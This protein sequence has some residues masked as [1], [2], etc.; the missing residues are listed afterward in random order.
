MGPHGAG[1]QLSIQVDTPMPRRS[2]PDTGTLDDVPLAD[3]LQGLEE[4][5]KEGEVR[6]E[7]GLGL[8][9][10]WFRDGCLLDAEMGDAHGEAAIFRLLGAGAGSYAIEYKSVA[11]LRM[12]HETSAALFGR[13]ARRTSEWQRLVAEMPSLDTVLTMD[14]GR[15]EALRTKVPP[16]DAKLLGLVDSKRS[17]VEIVDESGFE[18]VAALERLAW[19]VRA[20]LLKT[21]PGSLAPPPADPAA[22]SRSRLNALA[23]DLL[24]HESVIHP[25]SLAGPGHEPPPKPRPS[26]RPAPL[27]ES[28]VL[29]EIQAVLLEDGP[30]ERAGS[31]SIVP[32]PMVAVGR[33]ASAFDVARSPRRSL[34]PP[35]TQIGLMPPELT[36]K[37]A[38]ELS[39]SGSLPVRPSSRPP[40]SGREVD[41]W[42]GK[43]PPLL[44]EHLTSRTERTER[45]DTPSDPPPSPLLEESAPLAPERTVLGRYE[46]L[47]R[48]A[49]GGMGTVYLCRVTGEGG[50]RRLF[51]LKVL[52]RHLAR[53]ESAA[54]MFLQEAQVASRIYDPHVVGIVDVGSYGAQPYLVMDYVEGG[55]FHDLLQRHPTY[56]PPRLLVPILLDALQGLHAAHTLVD[57]RG[58][59][60]GLVH[61]D[62]SPH[63]LLVGIDGCGRLSDF[64]IAKAARAAAGSLRIATRGKP[65][66][67][68][69]EQ[70]AHHPVDPRTDVFSVG[71]VLWNALT[72]QRLFDGATV[73]ETIEN[74]LSRP[75]PPPSAVGLRPPP[76]LDSICLKALERK[77]EHRYQTAEEMMRDLRAVAIREDLLG[78]P[79]DVA[80]WV[81]ATFGPE[82]QARRLIA[83]DAS[84]RGRGVDV[85]RALPEA[86]R[87][88]DPPEAFGSSVSEGPPSSGPASS[89]EHSRTLSLSPVVPASEET[90]I[91]EVIRK[92]ILFVAVVVSAI[93]VLLALLFPQ[94]IARIFRLE[95]QGPLPRST[96]S[97]PAA[98]PGPRLG[99]PVP[100]PIPALPTTSGGAR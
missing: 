10:I 37:G 100:E 7:T 55:S 78:S 76:C 5:Q 26:P 38:P 87:L 88:S 32:T 93:A 47:S 79:G 91:P 16:V 43:L 45:A 57:D 42:P 48:I 99:Q 63:N 89:S 2:V 68:A 64:G 13:R 3:M 56:R 85:P 60:L 51:A 18:A 53:D 30:P 33:R 21:R 8:A 65:A 49:R 44:P 75:I 27:V 19:Y 41:T 12:I 29:E 83:L 86:D 81:A 82:L 71:V 80:R 28:A 84:R 36:A 22:E 61:C 9:R 35:R 40:R 77:P 66:Y 72:G 73:E 15:Y 50:F 34:S 54:A 74:V 90:T 96:F 97:R 23:R 24:T 14:P 4:S 20:R 59:P 94:G 1:L 98:E 58:A 17:I 11:R 70:A 69:P 95:Q 46:I 31:S 6:I 92:R 52:R 39:E 67:L 25:S 62:V